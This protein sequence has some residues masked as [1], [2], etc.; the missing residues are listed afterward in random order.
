MRSGCLLLTTHCSGPGQQQDSW[1]PC[2]VCPVQFVGLA[3]CTGMSVDGRAV[4]GGLWSGSSDLGNS[5][6]ADPEG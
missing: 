5:T 2:R 3:N 6:A 4:G 1:C